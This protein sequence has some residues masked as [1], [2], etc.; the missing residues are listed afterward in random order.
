MTNTMLRLD[1]ATRGKVSAARAWARR[2]RDEAAEEAGQG[3]AEYAIL[4]G[5]LVVIAIGAIIAISPIISD[6]WGDIQ[7]NMEQLDGA[8]GGSSLA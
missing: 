4:V 1:I 6:L 5:V 3:T 7:T 8:N 2:R